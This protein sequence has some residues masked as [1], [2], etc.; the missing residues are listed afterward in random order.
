MRQG[1]DR[2]SAFGQ[3]GWARQALAGLR[4]DWPDWAFL[5][6]GGRWLALRGKQ[7]VIGAVGPE[8]LRRALP[9]MALRCLPAGSGSAGSGLGERSAVEP[10]PPVSAVPGLLEVE[11]CESWAR[12]GTSPLPSAAAVSRVRTV[13]G[14]AGAGL[15]GPLVAVPS[16]AGVVAAERSGTGT[17]AVAAT[18]VADPVRVAWWPWGR[19]GGRSRTGA[20]AR[21]DG[22]RA[23]AGGTLGGRPRH[24]RVRSKPAAM[25]AVG[26]A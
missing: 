18:A 14:G 23:G 10:G 4:E 9:P 15:S 3:E 12:P 17:W 13:G 1:T 7:V 21:A 2:V 6:V 16:L 20:R 5:V 25:A 19:G 8:E 22:R 24:R 26:A 11:S